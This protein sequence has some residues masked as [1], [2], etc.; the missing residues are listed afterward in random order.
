MMLPIVVAIWP[1]S[2]SVCSGCLI[3]HELSW[4]TTLRFFSYKFK[5]VDSGIIPCFGTLINKCKKQKVIEYGKC[6]T[7]QKL[8]ISTY[9]D[10]RYVH[11][12]IISSNLS[13]S[14]ILM[15]QYSCEIL[16]QFSEHDIKIHY[17]NYHKISLFLFFL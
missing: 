5:W 15:I 6:L 16:I 2:L 4:M 12:W 9:L 10:D 7:I 17:Q 1:V 13:E 8:K 11:N 14:H 3:T